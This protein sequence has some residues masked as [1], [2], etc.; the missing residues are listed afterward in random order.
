MILQKPEKH[1]L[2]NATLQS[3]TVSSPLFLSSSVCFCFAEE[4]LTGEEEEMPSF[5]GEEISFR[6][7]LHNAAIPSFE[8]MGP[9]FVTD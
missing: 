3:I 7:A 8:S 2:C 1:I 6:L 9:V 5:R 4:D